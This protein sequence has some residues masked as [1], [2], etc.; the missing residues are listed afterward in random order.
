MNRQA[1]VVDTNIVFKA[2]RYKYSFVRSIISESRYHFYAPKFLIV[3]IFK[4]KEK[5]LKNNI[6]LEDE[7]Y[8]YLNNLLQHV[9]FVNE[10]IVSI[11]SYLEAYRLCRDT[12]EKDVPFVA[13]TLELNC[14]F[15]TYDQ[16]IKDGLRAKGFDSFF[17]IEN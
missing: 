3:E 12:D 14:L 8:E 9:T 10:D 15:W 13:L 7:L 4:H 16:P 6:Q 11:G 1:I 17:E 2:L 5:L